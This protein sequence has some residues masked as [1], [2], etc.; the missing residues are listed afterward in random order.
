M[1]LLTGYSGFLGKQILS[2][3]VN[4][5]CTLGRHDNAVRAMV[6]IVEVSTFIAR[7]K[8]SESGVFTLVS[9]H[10]SY[11]EV[12]NIFS[13]KHKKRIKRL[14]DWM[15][16]IA[17]KLG[18]RLLGFPINSYLLNKLETSLTCDDSDAR[19]AL[20]WGNFE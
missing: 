16:K 6:D 13:Q 2:E 5:F 20:G 8:G 7:L 18:D 4:D 9:F 14:P 15:V 19:Q 11:K 12:E 1:V 3:L 10:R 17:T